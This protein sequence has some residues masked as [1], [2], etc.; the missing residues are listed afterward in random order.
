M[1]EYAWTQAHHGHRHIMDTWT[2]AHHVHTHTQTYRVD[3][4]LFEVYIYS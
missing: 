3:P 2:Q 4:I 1:N